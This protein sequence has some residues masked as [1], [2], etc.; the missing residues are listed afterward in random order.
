[1]LDFY[2]EHRV[3]TNGEKTLYGDKL[4]GALALR[5]LGHI[6]AVKR[7]R[8]GASLSNTKTGATIRYA[9]FWTTAPP[10]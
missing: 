5:G 1:V 4:L 6:D 9:K 10:M 2:V 7:M 8:C 3:E